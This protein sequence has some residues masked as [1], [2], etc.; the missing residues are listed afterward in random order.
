MANMNAKTSRAVRP[1]S[2]GELLKFEAK[3]VGI[4]V[5]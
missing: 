3:V 2:R 4:A 1:G 5:G